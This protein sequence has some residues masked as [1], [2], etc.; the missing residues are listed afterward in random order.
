[1]QVY[2]CHYHRL[3]REEMATHSEEEGLQLKA[4]VKLNSNSKKTLNEIKT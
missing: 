2:W 1:M 4:D 3:L